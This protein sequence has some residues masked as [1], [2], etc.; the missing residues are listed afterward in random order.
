MPPHENDSTAGFQ[1]PPADG[2]MSIDRLAQA[3]AAMM[4]EPDP[5]ASAGG[6]AEQL[7]EVDASPDLDQAGGEPAAEPAVCRVDPRSIL[8][9]LLFVGLPG[10][11]PLSS[12]RVARLMRGVR[13][14]EID[15]LAAELAG[16]YAANGCPYEVVSKAS[17]WLLRL[18]NEYRQFGA[19]LEAK[20]RRVRLDAA[21]LDALAVV[22]WN[23]PVARSALA[24]LGCDASPAVLRQLVRRGLLELVKPSGDAAAQADSEP[25]YQTTQKFLEVFQLRSLADLPD[26]HEPPR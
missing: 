23:Q 18:R 10:G 4:G 5:Y 25:A 9:A 12:R 17:G 22:A 16:Q 24:E 8:E 11:E 19:V 2:G 13:A 7:V 3:F 21:A 14:A 1:G 26:P 20:T 6:G 15:A